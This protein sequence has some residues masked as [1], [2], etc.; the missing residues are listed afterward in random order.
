LA[1]YSHCSIIIT[2]MTRHSFISKL[3]I[4]LLACQSTAA[5]VSGPAVRVSRPAAFVALE[6]TKPSSEPDV[7][8]MMAVT[9]SSVPRYNNNSNNK[10][11]KLLT[12]AAVMVATSPLMA[13]A[14]EVDDYEYGSVDAPI[15][16]AWVAGVA[17]ILTAFLPVAL[18]GGEEAFEEMKKKDEKKWGKF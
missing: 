12:T 9:G 4:F 1:I 13:L 6:A 8:T 7:A 15:W 5:F 3:V 18:Q 14:E 17:V 10:L 11:T 2:T 16:I